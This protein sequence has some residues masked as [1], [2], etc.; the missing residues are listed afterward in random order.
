MLMSDELEASFSNVY[1]TTSSPAARFTNTPHTYLA[2][3]LPYYLYCFPKTIKKYVVGRETK[4]NI[5]AIE[6]LKQYVRQT[7]L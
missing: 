2:T 3:L 5:P 4:S 7:S 1:K 6:L